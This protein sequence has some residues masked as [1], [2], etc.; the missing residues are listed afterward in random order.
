MLSLTKCHDGVPLIAIVGPTA[1][2]KSH[3]AD[4][5]SQAYGIDQLSVDA[6]QV[7]RGMDIGTAKT[8]VSERVCTIHMLDVCD[9][10]E[11]Y[12]LQRFQQAARSVIE[13][14]RARCERLILCGGTGLYLQATIDD[15][16]LAPG[17]RESE[18]RVKL[19]Q[20]ALKTSPNELYERLKRL[21]PQSAAL[22]HPHNVRRVI[23]A[24]ELHAE[25]LSYAT[26]VSGIKNYVSFYPTKI[27]ALTMDRDRLYERIDM[28]VENM[29]EEGLV[30]EVASLL[31]RGFSSDT[32]AFQAIGY[33]EVV[34][35][36]KGETSYDEMRA[37]IQQRSRR[38]AKRQ[39]SWFKRDPRITWISLDT[40]THTEAAAY[41]AE[42]CALS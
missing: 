10:S 14:Y 13:T 36:L 8:P 39:L 28:R 7:Y 24:L 40:L 16:H 29:L 33:K 27:F 35:Y 19:E 3:I 18:L 12:S 17:H 21:D 5:L 15:M 34:G 22:I 30:P 6:M 26:Q 11:N 31:D 2:G 1:S 37:L 20:E 9:P 38:Y 25:G 42:A 41:I 23:R 4:L 32:T